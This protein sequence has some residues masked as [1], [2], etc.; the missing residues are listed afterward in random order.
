MPA[1]DHE[2]TELLEAL[3]SG[4]R[5]AMSQLMPLVYDQLRQAGRRAIRPR[6]RQPHATTDRAGP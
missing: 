6:A 5:D 4:N 3:S 1:A 2:V